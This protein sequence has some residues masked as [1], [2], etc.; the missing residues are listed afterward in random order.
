MGSSRKTLTLRLPERPALP[1]ASRSFPEDIL[2]VRRSDLTGSF[3][4]AEGD[5]DTVADA[6]VAAEGRSLVD[7]VA[8]SVSG[9]YGSCGDSCDRRERW[10]GMMVVMKRSTGRDSVGAT[11]ERGVEELKVKH[12]QRQAKRRGNAGDGKRRIAGKRMS[13]GKCE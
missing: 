13:E 2:R 10:S 3:G 6:E 7:L 8:L 12:Y 9:S 11:K 4:K 1:V 5:L